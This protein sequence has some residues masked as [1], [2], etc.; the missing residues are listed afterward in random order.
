VTPVVAQLSVRRGPEAVEFYKRGF[1][2]VEV[3]RVGG[4]ER[5]EA[6]VSQLGVGDGRT[7]GG[8]PTRSATTGRSASHSAG[9]GPTATADP[10]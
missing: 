1:G 9:G 4:D 10:H 8:S 3:Y 7:W 6:V 2:A 5:N